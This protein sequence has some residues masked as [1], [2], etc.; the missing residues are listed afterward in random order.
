MQGPNYRTNSYIDK[1]FCIYCNKCTTPHCNSNLHGRQLT[2][3]H[4]LCN[5][6]GKTMFGKNTINAYTNKI[7]P[8]IDFSYINSILPSKYPYIYYYGSYHNK[9]INYK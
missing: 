8:I 4:G 5:R 6:C 2:Y 1:M 3:D 9:L 7:P